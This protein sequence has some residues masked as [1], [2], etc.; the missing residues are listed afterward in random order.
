MLNPIG[1]LTYEHDHTGFNVVGGGAFG[2]IPAVSQAATR[3][4]RAS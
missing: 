2:G 3:F 4:L 1:S